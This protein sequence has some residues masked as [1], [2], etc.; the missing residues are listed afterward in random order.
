MTALEEP[1]IHACACP[2]CQAASDPAVV[3]RH[4]QINV[5]LS[6]LTEPQRRWY[7]GFL[8][9]EPAS[10]GLRQWVLI[11]GLARNTIRRGQQEL[12]AGLAD[13]PAVRQRRTGAGRPAAEK[14]T[15]F[16]KP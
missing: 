12:A 5:L 13:V 8:A 11:T 16:W 9:Q 3:S 15:R 7:V 10:P 6:R 2:I 1:A 4:H 14:K